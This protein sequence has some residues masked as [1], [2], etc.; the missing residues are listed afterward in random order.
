MRASLRK[1]QLF[2]AVKV[3]GAVKKSRVIRRSLNPDWDQ[4]FAF[5]VNSLA[6]SKLRLQVELH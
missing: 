6:N 2:K 3:D 5:E 4:S 1:R